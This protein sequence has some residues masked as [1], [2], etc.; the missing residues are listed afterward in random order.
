MPSASRFTRGNGRFG[1]MS[2]GRGEARTAS[3]SLSAANLIAMNGA[4]VA[5]LA[6]PG[7]GKAIVVDRILFKM[8]T[9]ATAFTSGG[10]VQFNYTGGSV[11]THAGTIPAAVVTAGAGTSYTELGPAVATNGTTLTANVGVSITNNTGA[12][13]TGTGTAVVYIE[14][15]VITLP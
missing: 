7:S 3:V 12:F 9:T 2:I 4:P 13:A 8:V 6:A 14:Y 11:A 15:R 10:T 5:I 1:S